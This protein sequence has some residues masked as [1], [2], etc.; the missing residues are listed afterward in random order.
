MAL[1][2]STGFV[3]DDAIVVMENVSRHLE[4]GMEPFRCRAQGRGGDW[5]HRSL[6]QCFAGRRLHSASAHGRY[7]R[8]A[9]SRICRHPFGRHRRFHADLAHHHSHDVR[10]PAA[11]RA[12]GKARAPLSNGA[13]A[14]SIRLLEFY[15]RTLHGVLDHPVLTLLVLFITIA[16]NVVLIVELPKGFFPVQDTGALNGG[17]QGPQDASFSSMNDSLQKIVGVIKAGSRGGECDRLHRRQRRHQYG[18][19]LRR[20]QA[21]QSSAK[22]ARPRSSPAF[23]PS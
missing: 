21:S 7:R 3:V 19:R 4:S 16:L 18:Q 20:A 2:I 13:K 17:M 12:P 14:P 9:V 15:R 6:H 1:T 8:A 10:R 23:G 5:L 22:P 11:R